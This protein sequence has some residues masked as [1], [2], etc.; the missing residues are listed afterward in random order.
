PNAR[1]PFGWRRPPQITNQTQYKSA[2][3]AGA[4]RTASGGAPTMSI[5]RL[6][7]IPLDHVVAELAAYP[8]ASEGA[9]RA[10]VVELDGT[11][12]DGAGRL[13]RSAENSLLG[14]FP[15]FSLDELVGLRDRIWFEEGD[16]AVPLDCYLRR[17]A[18]WFLQVNG[19]VAV[20]RLP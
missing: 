9:L 17:L 3:F 7:R 10:G 1:L 18:R 16:N 20:P 15:S 4:L 14:S 6:A 8:L 11:M 2:R 19:P 5:S 12:A 13:W